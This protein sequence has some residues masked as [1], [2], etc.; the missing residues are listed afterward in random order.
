M[1]TLHGRND[2]QVMCQAYW[3]APPPFAMRTNFTALLSFSVLLLFTGCARQWYPT[4]AV[5]EVK[6]QDLEQFPYHP[7]VY[8]LDLSI[9]SY[10]L[11]GQSLVWPFDP[12]YEEATSKKDRVALMDKVRDWAATKGAEQVASTKGLQAYRGPGLLNGF[13]DNPSH[14]PI[15]YRYDR[16][17]PWSS[18]LTNPLNSWTEYLVPAAITDN[19][20][21]L[22]VGYRKAG[23]PQD[24][25]TVEQVTSSAG[26][27]PKA[28]DVLLA[29]EGGTG[30]KGIEGRPPSQS[31][32]GFVLLRYYPGQ[33]D[34]D[35]HITFRGSRSGS[36]SRAA[37]QALS[38]NKAKGNPDW[39][40]DLGYNLIGPEEGERSITQLGSISRGMTTC[41]NSMNPAL[42]E[43]LKKVVSLTKGAAPKRIFV[44]GHSLGG[45]LAQVF[46]SSVLMG[47]RNT[48]DDL[49]VALRP[50]PWKEMKLITFSAPRVGD[51]SWAE[52]LTVEHLSMDF[53]STPINPYDRRALQPADLTIIP[54]LTDPLLP[55]GY[56]VLVP[57][58]PISSQKVPGGKHVGKTVYLSKPKALDAISPPSFS[59]HEPARLREFLVAG[60]DDPRIPA[61]AWKTYKMTMLN[62]EREKSGK[63]TVVEYQKLIASIERYYQERGLYFNLAVF[64]EDVELFL[65]IL[66]VDAGAP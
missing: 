44:T 54:R 52:A 22:Y 14:D 55:S 12:Y 62:P 2:N 47:G 36:G 60:L 61:E 59:G 8:H 51:A 37:L 39:I 15:L 56:R 29:F 19:I 17:H 63:G 43:C 35:I 38:D 53:F 7:L 26:G 65:E 27:A 28:R 21:D 34:F 4:A 48:P 3:F 5:V 6:K 16:L 57:S 58:D 33:T 42:F 32:M 30:D 41:V 13:A 24:S 46:V 20:R 40:T 1:F 9:L 45:G 50:W 31:L 64:K 25:V 11:Y 66:G 10:Q 23:A 49:P 18:N